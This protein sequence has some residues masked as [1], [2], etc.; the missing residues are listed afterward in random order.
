LSGVGRR[1]WLQFLLTGP[2]IAGPGIG[3]AAPLGAAPQASTT[4]TLRATG[5][6]L[7]D[8]V[9]GSVATHLPSQQLDVGHYPEAGNFTVEQIAAV[10][11]GHVNQAYLREL[12][13]RNNLSSD[14]LGKPLGMRVYDIEWPACLWVKNLGTKVQYRVRSGDTFSSIR[15]LMTGVPGTDASNAHYFGVPTPTVKTGKLFPGMSLSIPYVTWATS[16]P[17][18]ANSDVDRIIQTAQIASPSGNAN[19]FL[20]IVPPKRLGQIVTYVG[21]GSA[22]LEPPECHDVGGPPFD[23][24]R[25]ADMYAFASGRAHKLKAPESSVPVYV[26]DNGFFGARP[27]LGAPSHHSK[28][29]PEFYFNTFVWGAGLGPTF[30]NGTKDVYPINYLNGMNAADNL[31]GHGTHVTGLILGGPGWSTYENTTFGSADHSWMQIAEINIGGGAADLIPRA[32]QSLASM[33]SLLSTPSIVNMSI[34][35]DSTAEGVPGSF[36]FMDTT[37]INRLNIPHLYI[38][39]AGNDSGDA[40]NYFPA[41][42]GGGAASPSVITVAA[43]GKDDALTAF[44]NTGGTVDIAAPGCNVSS[45]IDDSDTVVALSGTSQAAPTVTFEAA[46]LRS[47]AGASAAQLKMRILSSGDLLSAPDEKRLSTPVTADIPKSLYLFDDY[48]RYRDRTG[49]HESLGDVLLVQG[50]ACRGSAALASDL[51]QAYKTDGK[52]AFTFYTR[53]G[54]Q[55]LQNCPAQPPSKDAKVVVRLNYR[56]TTPCCDTDTGSPSIPLSDVIEFIRRGPGTPVPH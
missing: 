1:Q 22:V 5:P 35:F 11:C 25:V 31:S 6:Q 44:T 16:F 18:Q 56:I 7:P 32:E 36:A 46:L 34:S 54:G 37:A 27:A 49:E 12:L 15:H 48:V 20:Q 19:S 55:V 4:V 21:S 45:W 30:H 51:V 26:I 24:A 42:L 23:A 14:A 29:F 52:R 50:V 9:V 53:P 33:L 40:I 3:I 47:L 13:L 8:E 38:V 39:A 2:M 17:V 41:A 43:T 28:H 10:L